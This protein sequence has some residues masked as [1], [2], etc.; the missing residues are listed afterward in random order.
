[1]GLEVIGAGFGRTG[2]TSLKA[3]LERLGF[4]PCYHMS[5]LFEHP[6]HLALWQAAVRG[7]PV[8]WDALFDGYRSAVD[9]PAAAFYEE[10]MERY[11]E[12]K[13]ILTVRDPE[14]WYESTKSTIYALRKT[15][16]TP[17]FRIMAALVPYLRNIRR[18][19][20][21]VDDLAWEGIF[22]GRFEDRE[23]AISVFDNLNEEA[24][25]RIPADRLLVYEVKE[26]WGPLCAFLGVEEPREEPF[27]RLND[28]GTFRR[29]IRLASTLTAA[30][31]ISA[32]LLA[33]ALVYLAISR[34]PSGCPRPF[35]SSFPPSGRAAG[36]A[37]AA[38]R[39][40]RGPTATA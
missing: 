1:M 34:R 27:P 20:G 5:E 7:E 2:T 6:E 25:R 19:T 38:P 11:P 10:L 22:G 33:L 18:A 23:H 26:G 24:K 28:T 12:A 13:V 31:V 39:P 4:G 3:A 8:D 37:S 9:W 17:T 35:P 15:R 40:R 30:G 29:R 32:A 16:R 36:T 21:I 14:R